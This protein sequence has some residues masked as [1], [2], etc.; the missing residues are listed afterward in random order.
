MRCTI[1]ATSQR[2]AL[3]FAIARHPA[4]LHDRIRILSKSEAGGLLL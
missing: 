1:K 2:Q 4:A 3:Q